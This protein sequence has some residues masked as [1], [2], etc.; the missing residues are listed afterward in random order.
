LSEFSPQSDK[1]NPARPTNA[2][3][4]TSDSADGKSKKTGDGSIKYCERESALK[5]AFFDG[6]SS[7]LNKQSMAKQDTIA[8]NSFSLSKSDP[9]TVKTVHSDILQ[10]N[11]SQELSAKKKTGPSGDDSRKTYEDQSE[12]RPKLP[13]NPRMEIAKNSFDGKNNTDRLIRNAC[14][15][16]NVNDRSSP[17]DLYSKY[18]DEVNNNEINKYSEGD[19]LGM[20]DHD[21]ISLWDAPG[22]KIKYSQAQQAEQ[23][24]VSGGESVRLGVIKEESRGHTERYNTVFTFRDST[25]VTP[26]INLWGIFCL[27]KI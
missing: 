1:S 14:T 9:T 22:I 13:T 26:G 21:G 19:G 23:G 25:E 20:A 2:P 5:S 24:L 15:G 16:G 12:L 4:K 8:S 27:G 11:E 6:I 18:Q 17:S 7:L 10:V 3:V